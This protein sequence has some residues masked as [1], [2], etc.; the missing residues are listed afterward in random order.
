MSV[1]QQIGLGVFALLILPL[2]GII[3]AVLLWLK[4]R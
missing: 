3:A 2:V 1:Q 4:R